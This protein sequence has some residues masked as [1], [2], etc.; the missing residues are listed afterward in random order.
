MEEQLDKTKAR[1]ALETELRDTK[2][3]VDKLQEDLDK[4]RTVSPDDWWDAS[5]ERVSEYID[6][7]EASIKR[8][9]DN[10]VQTEKPR[11]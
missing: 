3:R 10:K 4:L 6:R 1:G 5:S 2:A 11:G 8:L 9:D 7:V